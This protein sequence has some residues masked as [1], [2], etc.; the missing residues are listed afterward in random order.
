MPSR[1]CR[2][3]GIEKPLTEFTIKTTSNMDGTRVWKYPRTDCKLCCAAASRRRYAGDYA[4]GYVP[5]ER[6]Y[7]AANLRLH[8]FWRARTRARRRGATQ[9][10]SLEEWET[11]R[12][13]KLCHWCGLELHPSFSHVDH[14]IPLC[15]GGQ[16]TVENVVLSCANCNMRREWERKTI[17]LP[18][19]IEELTSPERSPDV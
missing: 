1:V 10:M 4:H 19:G 16:H 9:F 12:S 5:V 6:R 8:D 14:V 17:H 7:Y 15:E 11:L 18:K 2:T 3:C 13:S